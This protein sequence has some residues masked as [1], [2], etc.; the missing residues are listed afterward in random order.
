MGYSY[1]GRGSESYGWPRW[2]GDGVH[3]LAP[4]YI[5]GSNPIMGETHDG[6]LC[7]IAA[8]EIGEITHFLQRE[9]WVWRVR[10]GYGIDLIDP[11]R[12]DVS[13]LTLYTG[14]V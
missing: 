11:A 12:E 3:V 6:E 5:E 8:E 10:F 14:F 4:N 13:R 1:V 2:W 9:G 7:P